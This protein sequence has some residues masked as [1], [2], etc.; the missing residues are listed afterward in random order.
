M[1]AGHC[2][3]MHRCRSDGSRLTDNPDTGKTTVLACAMLAEPPLPAPGQM[4]L[5]IWPARL[6]GKLAS[7]WYIWLPQWSFGEHSKHSSEFA[8]PW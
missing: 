2:E 5:T 7:I 4:R 1:T 6:A 3:P 8:Q